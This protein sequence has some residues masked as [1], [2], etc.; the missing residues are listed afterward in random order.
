MAVPLPLSPPHARATA[1]R[2]RAVPDGA[3]LEDQ[4]SEAA[5]S[6]AKP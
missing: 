5:R 4:P 2:F 1:R 3:F 6:Q